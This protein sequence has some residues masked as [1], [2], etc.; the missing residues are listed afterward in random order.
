MRRVSLLIFALTAA[1]AACGDPLVVLGD[2]PGFMR[3]VAGT[4]MS[5]GEQIDSLATKSRLTSPTSVVPLDNGDIL[6]LD[7]ARRILRVTQSNHIERLYRGVDCFD[8][9]CLTG[10]QGAVLSGQ[11]L[12]IADNLSDHVWGFDLQSRALTSYA[13]TGVH[14]IAP[15]GSVAATSPLASPTDVELLPDGRVLIAERE[16]NRIRIVGS[17]GRLQTLAGTGTA[18]Y[19][20]D[21]GP[22]LSARLNSPTSLALGGNTLYFTDNANHVVRAIDLATGTIR[23]VAGTNLPGFSG[24]GGPATAAKLDSP[25][26]IALAPDGKSLFFTETGNDRVRVVN[27]L[28]GTISSYAGTGATEFNG[29]GRSAG[30]TA[31]NNPNGVAISSLNQLYIADTGHQIVWRTPIRF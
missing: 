30:E 14:A 17:D 5:A 18:G 21:G 2:L 29:N 28:N 7:Q 13:G 25:W 6:V 4:P 10:P 12:L 26:S 22:A 20:G 11:A 27:L 31:L 23:T 15:D 3:V 1:L 24:D 19:S 9:T 16:A 8:Q